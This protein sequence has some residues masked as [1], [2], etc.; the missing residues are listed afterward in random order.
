MI[1]MRLGL[2]ASLLVAVAVAAASDWPDR[3]REV[4]PSGVTLTEV[5]E[6]PGSLRVVGHAKGNPEVAAFMRALLQ[7]NLGNPELQQV[8][9][10]GDRSH[11]VLRIEAKP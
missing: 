1:L 5:E 8:Q 7:A 2:A 11:F 10:E 6:T 9:R 3:V 4:A